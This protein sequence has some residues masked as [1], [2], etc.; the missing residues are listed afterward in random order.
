MSNLSSHNFPANLRPRLARR[1]AAGLVAA[2][3]T[4]GTVSVSA[5]VSAEP[6][7]AAILLTQHGTWQGFSINDRGATLVGVKAE[8]IKGGLT[9]FLVKGDTL[10]LV[11]TDPNWDLR[12]GHRTPVRVQ[13]DDETFIGTAIVS[14]HDSIEIQNVSLNVLKG[15]ADGAKAVVNVNEGEIVWTLDLDGFTAAMSDALKRYSNS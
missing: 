11:L 2:L 6:T 7:S 5:V 14:D 15:F 1:F 10:S 8:M 9:A 4:L 13:I 3:L 12:I